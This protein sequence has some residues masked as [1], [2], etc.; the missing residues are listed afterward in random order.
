[1]FRRRT[2]LLGAAALCAALATFHAPG[3]S[4]T[5][6]VP[7]LSDSGTDSEVLALGHG[8]RVQ[9]TQAG[10]RG[11]VAPLPDAAGSTPGLLLSRDDAGTTVQSTLGSGSP[12][13]IEGSAP[14][15]TTADGTELV[16]LHFDAIGRDGRVA[17]ADVTVFDVETGAT[18]AVRRIPGDA[19]AE[20]STKSFEDS[21]CVLVP[22]GTYSAMAFVTTMPADRPGTARERTTQNLSLVGD[23]EVTID[24]DRGFTFDAR[25]ANPVEVR[26]P[27]HR[28]KVNSDGAMQL[29]YAR[30]AANGRR[31][32]R[33]YRPTAML[34]QR[35]FMQPTEP[36]AHGDLETL[37][38]LRLQAPDIELSVG[39]HS[40]H[41]EY[42]DQVWFSDVI[43]EFPRFDGRARLRVVD[44]GHATA[45]DLAGKRLRG[46]IAVAERTDELSVAEQS[47]AAAAAGAAL[48]VVHHD[49]P[50]DSD[51]PNGTGIRLQVPTL[52]L[53]R[54]EGEALK[55][56]RGRVRVRGES[57]SPYLYD[58]VL[59]EHGV[60][61]EDL[62]HVARSRDLA[63]QVREV[64]GQPTIDATFS[65]AAYQYQPGD[66]FSIS[67]MFPFPDGA[68]T[69]VEYRIPDPDTRWSYTTVTPQTTYNALFPHPPV[70][71]MSLSDPE[72]EAYEST[73]RTAK[74]V[75]TAP[76][77]AAPSTFRPMER[78]GDRMQ[79]AIEGFV[80]ADGN[81]GGS[82]STDSG[83]S[84]LLQIRADG[85]LVGETDNQPSGVA[86]LP[87]GDSTVEVSF[88]ADNPQ[89]WAELSTRTE[90]VWTFPSSTVPTGGAVTQPVIVADYDV[91][92][93]LRNRMQLRG[94]HAAEFDLRLSH[95]HG[96]AASP[97]SDVTV[98]AS[99]DDGRTWRAA[100]TTTGAGGSWHVLLPRGSGHVSLR[101]HA[102]DSAG[103]SL[104]QTITRAWYVVR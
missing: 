48:V 23:P 72:L 79:V 6:A 66:T 71:R 98:E 74:P 50:G 51:D 62:T 77:T 2:P 28:T 75:G 69:R 83:M 56:A 76:V 40:L 102:A 37:T 10:G 57:A 91:A 19:D 53:D 27:D 4:G 15:R 59:K 101:L 49:G 89:S 55:A 54:T 63:S 99:Y 16:E 81:H 35:L 29:G 100:R 45:A 58:L 22:P 95:V 24:E 8:Q 65:D 46:A 25:L 96:A 9:V 1:M 7:D 80:D 103:S 39:G 87:P 67:T 104:D 86:A 97:I 12:T 3:A 90:S 44:V 34:D 38:W 43:T 73:E 32:V 5:T 64:H 92:L 26:T 82:Y 70:L 61:P 78:S 60:I 88:V 30:T 85:V 94:N 33:Q 36:V 93:D 41:P 21:A 31:V 52:R 11:V 20:C 13:L 42:Y 14:V 68:R 17:S 18:Q 84:T 47:N